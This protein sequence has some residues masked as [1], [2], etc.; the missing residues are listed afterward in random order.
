MK[1]TVVK[2]VSIGLEMFNLADMHKISLS[3]AVKVGISV[4]LAEKGEL[5]Y[6]NNLNYQR[7]IENMAQIIAEMSA[8]LEEY[9]K[10]GV[11]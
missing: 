11:V 6:Q 1:G 3:E 7:K 2:S 5:K 4:L 8:K 10:N 9:G